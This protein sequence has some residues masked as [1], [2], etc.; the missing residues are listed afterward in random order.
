MSRHQPFDGA[1]FGTEYCWPGLLPRH[2]HPF[3]YLCVVLKG[4]FVE[5][6]DRGRFRV[7]AGDVLV[8]RP[9]EGHFDSFGKWGAVVLNL[10]FPVHVSV[11][12]GRRRAVNF[13]EA[14]RLAEHDPVEAAEALV[15]GWTE[16]AGEEDWPDLL[17]SDL[18]TSK[19]VELRCWADAHD[20][21]PETLSRGF[22]KAYGVTPARFAAELRA[23][24][25][26]RDIET[27]QH[28]LA[29]IALESHFA[30]QSHMSRA[31]KALTGRSPRECRRSVQNHNL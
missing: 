12:Q 5:A 23:R 19:R 31:V 24:R 8:H 9:Y 3:P 27:T 29:T 6:G 30:D 25:A 18:A 10:P 26:L 15:E 7:C 21:A 28:G 2:C 17:A 4:S 22:R 13:D 11:E 16:A 1:A 14:A 20:L